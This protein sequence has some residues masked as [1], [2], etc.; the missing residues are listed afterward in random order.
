MVLASG[1]RIGWADLP[2][3]VRA[4]VEDILGEPVA[5]AVSQAGGFS[6]G[7]ADRVVTATG[8]RSF[9]KAVGAALNPDSP[10]LHR[11]EAAV[12]AQLPPGLPTP[13]LLGTHDDGD[14]V[15]LVYADVDG[16]HPHTPW[17]DDEAAAVLEALRALAVPVRN[18]P[19]L[20]D[21]T[22]EDFAGWRAVAA[23]P[24]A[25]LDPWAARHLDLLAEL[26]ERGHAALAGDALVHGDVRADNLLIRPD[27]TVVVVDWPFGCAGP[28]WFDALG[29]VLN[30]RLYGGRITDDVIGGDPA[31]V[32][33]CVAGLAG[34]FADRARRPDPPGLPTLRRFQQDQADVMLTWLRER[35]GA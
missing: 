17:R 16:R 25:T 4:A 15:A 27:G 9:V 35:L 14:W 29:L 24:P 7:T 22:V 12:V 18:L 5:S 13:P 11:A 20:Q 1:V 30:I 26:S 33:G 23:D 28:P 6:P 21:G 10:A 2:G 31:D 3:G 19:K 8:R 34:M 32:T